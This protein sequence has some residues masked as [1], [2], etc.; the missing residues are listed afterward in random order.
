VPGAHL[1]GA[2]IDNFLARQV[3]FQVR[4]GLCFV[5]CFVTGAYHQGPQSQG[6]VLLADG[7][8]D[9]ENKNR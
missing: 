5:H 3:V 7:I 6:S 9:R 4:A 8:N 2:Q 1:L